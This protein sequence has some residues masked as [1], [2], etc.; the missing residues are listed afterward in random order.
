VYTIFS[1]GGECIIETFKNM[2]TGSGYTQYNDHNSCGIIKV[3]SDEVRRFFSGDMTEK[4]AFDNN[5]I[6]LS[7]PAGNVFQADSSS[8]SIYTPS[9]HEALYVE[10]YWTALRVTGADVLIGEVVS[11]LVPD[12]NTV[13]LSRP[14]VGN[15]LYQNRY[16][17]FFKDSNLEYFFTIDL[18]N[19]HRSLHNFL[20]HLQF[21]NFM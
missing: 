15:I 2:A 3:D 11:E 1:S 21:L 7:L 16:D 13:T 5:S 12:E 19:N 18:V 10:D 17:T 20:I 14:N 6:T 8:V 9:G 4:I